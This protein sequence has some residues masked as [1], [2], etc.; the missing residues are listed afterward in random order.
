MA[1]LSEEGM[2]I[3]MPDNIN[4]AADEF[5]KSQGSKIGGKQDDI[6][7]LIDTPDGQ[8]VKDMM[9]GRSEALMDALGKGDIDTLKGALK[10]ILSTEEGARLA[11]NLRDIIK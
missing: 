4:S 8:K 6:K 3:T 2:V 11:Q 7:K 10:D 9:S 5:I 1:L